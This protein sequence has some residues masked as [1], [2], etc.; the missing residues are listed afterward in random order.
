M[1]GM[2]IKDLKLL[3]NQRNSMFLFCV[4]GLMLIFTNTS[5][6]FVLAYLTFL[7][8]NIAL[9]TISYDNMDNNIAFLF[10]LPVSKKG[11]VTEKYLFTVVF[12][13]MAWIFSIAFCILCAVVQKTGMITQEFFAEAPVYLMVVFL[14]ASFMIPIQV[15]FG[16]EKAKI[17]IVGVMGA[18]FLAIV[19]AG[20]A[21]KRTGI[22][23]NEMLG[24]FIGMRPETRMLIFC[25]A[26][27]VITAVSWKI[28]WKILEG[29]EF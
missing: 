16:A 3:K 1:K 8:C 10:T 29:K 20:R 15:K 22:N 23:V 9:S 24:N 14:I 25:L 19:L 28:S 26:V 11:Y 27:V 12:G 17:I 6:E 5:V 13:A 2:L 18:F 4:I 7:F 21:V